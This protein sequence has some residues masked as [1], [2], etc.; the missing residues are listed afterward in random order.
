[1]FRG[2]AGFV[3]R[4]DKLSVKA[5][6]TDSKFIVGTIICSGTDTGA[7]PYSIVACQSINFWLSF[8]KRHV[9]RLEKLSYQLARDPSM[10][11]AM[12]TG[13]KSV[14]TF[15]EVNSSK[16]SLTVREG[17]L[18]KRTAFGHFCWYTF[19]NALAHEH[20]DCLRNHILKICKTVLLQM[21]IT[22]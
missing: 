11:C 8:I 18:E 3:I 6:R 12:T 20:L 10:P 19:N 15:F 17:L 21:N 7:P 2:S 9:K 22:Y 5:F 14:L 16:F 13:A 4:T 1:M